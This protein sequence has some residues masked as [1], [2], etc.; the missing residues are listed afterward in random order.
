LKDLFAVA[1]NRNIPIFPIFTSELVLGHDFQYSLA[2][3]PIFYIFDQDDLDFQIPSLSQII[4]GIL[5][6]N[7]LKKRKESIIQDIEEH[8]K[9][10]EEKKRSQ[11]EYR[12]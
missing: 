8:L 12:Y 11:T 4:N 7:N 3:S 10:E 2:K 6:I 5:S 9:R 1:E